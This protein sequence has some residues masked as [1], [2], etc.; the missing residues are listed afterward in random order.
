MSTIDLEQ[1]DV[2]IRKS[3]CYFCHNNCGVL[4]YVKDGKV[5]KFEGDPDHPAN[6]GGLCCR[7]QLAL[8]HLDHPARVN[9]PLKRIGPKGSGQWE[10][11]SWEQAI[12]EI[13]VKLEQIKTEFG[14]EAVATAGGT[15]RTDDWARRRFMNIFGSP[16]CFHNA[17][18]CWIPTFMVETAI[19]GWSPFEIDL[20]QS[21]C[22]VLW[23]QNPGTANMPEMA[24]ITMLKQQQGLKVIVIDP[25]Y[26]ETAAKADLW[27]PVR[28]GSDLALLLAWINVIIEEGLCD[29]DFLTEHCVGFDELSEHIGQ[30]TPEW[31][32]P[33]T[34]L[35][36]EKIRAGA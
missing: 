11:I 25:K 15:L 32:A 24:G 2:Q 13:A 23:G 34:W 31:A 1:D 21:R 27:L 14:A 28:P 30:Y 20:G 3:C 16:N 8:K 9:K 36:P 18:M 4:A 29:Y 19:Y 6:S 5:V 10:E 35:D 12:D 17:H 33:L 7:G 22:I 26:S